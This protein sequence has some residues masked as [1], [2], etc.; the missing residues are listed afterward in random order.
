MVN[1]YFTNKYMLNGCDLEE[2]LKLIHPN[3]YK[4]LNLVETINSIPK[5]FLL[6]L[7]TGY[8]YCY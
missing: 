1:S 2:L 6:F 5:I 4:S 8:N 3:D 7:N